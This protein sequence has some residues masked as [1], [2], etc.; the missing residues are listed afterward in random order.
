MTQQHFILQEEVTV[1]QKELSSVVD[2][3]CN[4]RK[5]FDK[6]INCLQNPLL[7]A[8]NEIESTKSKNNLIAQN[9]ID[10]IEHPNRQIRLSFRFGNNNSCVFSIKKFELHGDKFILTETL[11]LNHREKHLHYRNRYYVANKCEIIEGNYDV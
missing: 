7:K 1:S 5:T 3:L 4:F 6:A 11:N 8:K 9:Y 2:S 10:M